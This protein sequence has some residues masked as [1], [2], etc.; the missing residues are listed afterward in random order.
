M[1]K[2]T[3]LPVDLAE[4]LCDPENSELLSFLDEDG[5]MLRFR[6][7]AVVPL[8]DADGKQTLYCMLHPLDLP[9]VGD[10]EAIVY[11]VVERGGETTIEITEDPAVCARVYREYQRA[12]NNS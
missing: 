3:L 11:T 4:V 2:E 7:V 9:E 5:N 10:D 1:K 12:L 8:A 6:Q